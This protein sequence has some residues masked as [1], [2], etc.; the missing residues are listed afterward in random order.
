MQ[1]LRTCQINVIKVCLK[2]H[3]SK[4]NNFHIAP[5][6]HKAKT[7]EPTQSSG[8]VPPEAMSFASSIC[9]SY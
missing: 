4:S 1:F 2:F 3:A 6:H 9:W 8:N 7:F 5:P